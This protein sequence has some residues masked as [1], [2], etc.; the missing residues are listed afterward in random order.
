MTSRSEAEATTQQQ[1]VQQIQPLQ[2]QGS[3]PELDQSRPPKAR[4][5]TP[6]PQ[7]RTPRGAGQRRSGGYEGFVIQDLLCF[8]RRTE[9]VCNRTTRTHRKRLSA[10]FCTSGRSA[11]RTSPPL[12]AHPHGWPMSRSTSGGS[13]S[14]RGP[15]CAAP[16]AP[17]T[18]A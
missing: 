12:P 13:A 6:P 18:S 9:T 4:Q 17:M 8:A 11:R 16:R 15:R 14:A 5:I 3:D 1:P 7:P 2:K 10:D